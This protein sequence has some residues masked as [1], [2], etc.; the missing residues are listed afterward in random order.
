[1]TVRI[2]LIF[3]TN[4]IGPEDQLFQKANSDLLLAAYRAHNAAVQALVPKDKLLVYRI[5]EG[6][7]P[8]T[9]RPNGCEVKNDQNKND[10]P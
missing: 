8:R 4:L 1:M 3:R 7:V 9:L 10:D 5:G 6:R 2:T